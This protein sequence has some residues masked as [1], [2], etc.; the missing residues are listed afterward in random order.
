MYKRQLN[1]PSATYPNYSYA[2]V[3]L[4]N[5]NNAALVL[6]DFFTGSPF[7]QIAQGS[8][9][10]DYVDA[11]ELIADESVKESKLD[12][13]LKKKLNDPIGKERLQDK[14]VTHEKT[15]LSR[16]TRNFVNNDKSFWKQGD[17]NST[18]SYRI[19]SNAVYGLVKNKTYTLQY[20]QIA[21]LGK[22]AWLRLFDSNNNYLSYVQAKNG[23]P[24]TIT[25]DFS[26]IK[27]SL[28]NSDN[29]AADI[30]L[31]T[32]FAAGLKLQIEEGTKPTEFVDWYE[33]DIKEGAIGKK[34]LHDKV[35]TSEKMDIELLKSLRSIQKPDLKI[36]FISDIHANVNMSLHSSVRLPH[37]INA[38]HKE[39][40]KGK[41]DFI[42]INGDLVTNTGTED[43]IPW[44][45]NNYL[46]QL[47]IPYYATPGN[48]DHYT[49][50]KW[51]NTFGYGKN[52]ICLLYT[53]PS[54]RD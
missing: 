49:E 7:I 54:P 36:V 28:S 12:T 35:V 51:L 29:F 42:V 5:S 47:R 31:D 24:F 20:N 26:Y 17:Y 44:F 4:T 22:Y 48:H 15:I 53:S 45:I 30:N 23:D 11:F 39:D 32:V 8:T 40:E 19:S 37:M 38:L 50:Q 1:I 43:N 9:A 46:S 3:V 6:N 18:A 10:S 27:I 21:V 52:Y 25:N 41:I 16:K 2:R 13:P 14:A 33:L 34:E